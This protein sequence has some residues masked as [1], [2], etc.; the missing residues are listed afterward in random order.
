MRL[1]LDEYA[2]HC[3]GGRGSAAPLSAW[4]EGDRVQRVF[5]YC[6]VRRGYSRQGEDRRRPGNQGQAARK[7]KNWIEYPGPLPDS[8]PSG[9]RSTV[10]PGIV[11]I[12]LAVALC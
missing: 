9:R 11:A 8:T 12:P 4:V 7:E 1:A 10:G 3:R 6:E 5:V 2:S